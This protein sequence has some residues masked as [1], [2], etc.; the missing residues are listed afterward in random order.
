[1]HKQTADV[2]YI[3]KRTSYTY[4]KKNLRHSSMLCL[5]LGGYNFFFKVL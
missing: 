2:S 3:I 5:K 4:I 1:M